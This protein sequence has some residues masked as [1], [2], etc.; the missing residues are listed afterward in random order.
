MFIFLLFDGHFFIVESIQERLIV[1]SNSGRTKCDRGIFLTHF[2]RKR[3][4]VKREMG[5]FKKNGA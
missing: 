4:I 1:L 3:E 2:L 5:N